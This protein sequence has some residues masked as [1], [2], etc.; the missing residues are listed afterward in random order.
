MNI[1]LISVL[2][3]W[4]SIILVSSLSLFGNL[5]FQEKVYTK[6]V[7]Y[8]ASDSNMVAEVLKYGTVT[9]Y[10]TNRPIGIA[11]TVTKGKDGYAYVDKVTG[12]QVVIENKTDEVVEVGIGEVG[13]YT[14]TLT[15]YGPDCPG[16]SSVGNVSC[17]TYENAK[18]SLIND[19]VTYVDHEYGTVRILAA[20]LVKFP[21][22]TII[23]IDNGTLK[24]FYGIVLDT[25]YTMRQAYA[26]G[27]IWIDL[28]FPA[29]NTALTAG[30]TSYNTKYSVVRWGW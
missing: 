25:G 10:V 16:C 29:E 21:C 5:N 24:P 7:K 3:K 30:A 1:Y 8:T 18:H 14:G 15:G 28:A 27:N 22:G 13:E 23:Y 6:Q 19:G 26:N 17:R 20:A 12:N 9:K 4:L 2:N 11:Y